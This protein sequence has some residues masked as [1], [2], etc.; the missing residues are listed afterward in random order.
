MK[1]T[2]P[3]IGM[4]LKGFPRISET[5]ISNEIALLEELGFKI[6]IISMRRPRESF[7]HRS[8]ERIK[9]PVFY[10][11]SQ[12][13]GNLIRLAWANLAV[14]VQR[15]AAYTHALGV[16][17]EKFAHS[18]SLATLKH[19][20]QAGY[21]VHHA[22]PGQGVDRL[23]AHFAHSPTSV[24]QFAHLLT[25]LPF[26]FTGHAKDIYT[27]RPQALAD[28]LS[29]ADLVVT[30]TDYNRRHLADLNGAR[31]QL[32]YH[33]IDNSLFAFRGVKHP[34]KGADA[35]YRILCV[36]RMV[37]KK[38]LDILLEAM[39]HL[40]RRGLNCR[41]RHIGDGPL[42]E[43]LQA[44]SRNLGLE[45]SVEWL[46]VLS[47]EHVVEEYNRADAFALACRIADNGD[48]DGIPNVLA[49]SM[50]VGA[51]VVGVN[52]SGIPE[53]VEHGKTGL[54]VEPADPPALADAL[55]RV[56]TDAALRERII[57]A[58]REKVVNDFDNRRWT[59]KL[60]E[61][62]HAA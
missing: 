30:C 10:L 47:H 55:E 52:L 22:L 28:K 39:A 21:L 38:G 17:K 50:A 8:V 33:G 45:D 46:G 20:L 9:A 27:Q 59:L 35:P 61:V 42:K 5:F 58:A 18:R 44:R 16:M 1:T 49:E 7:T 31:V 51:P 23:H 13:R 53:L 60:A 11:P 32:V 15:P 43:S 54:L 24:A 34:E 62:F 14:F 48:R 3:V 6:V 40:R 57:P 36:A 2:R 19:L 41:L 26:G 4:I 56:L 25:G 37:E 12:L 29:Q